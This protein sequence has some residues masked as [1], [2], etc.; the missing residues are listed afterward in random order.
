MVAVVESNE[1]SNL[2]SDRPEENYQST[3]HEWNVEIDVKGQVNTGPEQES[4]SFSLKKLLQY[5]GPGI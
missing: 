2:I 4:H 1:R 5:T 3:E